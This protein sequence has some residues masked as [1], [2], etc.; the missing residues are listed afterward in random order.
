MLRRRQPGIPQQPPQN[1]ILFNSSHSVKL[2]G[3][4]K[5]QAYQ[6]HEGVIWTREYHFTDPSHDHIVIQDHAAGHAFGEGG[7][8][9]Q[10]PHFNVRPSTNLDTGE[11]PGTL[12]HYGFGDWSNVNGANQ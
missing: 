4:P 12:G 2:R 5:A 7:K 3:A 6:D 1:A 11:V 9:D 10:G 8:G